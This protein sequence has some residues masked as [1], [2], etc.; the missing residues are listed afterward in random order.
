MLRFMGASVILAFIGLLLL[1]TTRSAGPSDKGKS[2]LRLCSYRS[3]SG[4]FNSDESSLWLDSRRAGKT[5]D[6][7]FPS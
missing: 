6:G 1:K 7:F 5:A 3:N 2:S 4:N